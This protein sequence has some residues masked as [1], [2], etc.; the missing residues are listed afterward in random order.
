MRHYR[1][2]AHP[3]LQTDRVVSELIIGTHIDGAPY[4]AKVV[5]YFT[6]EGSFKYRMVEPQI[7][8]E[9]RNFYSG[10]CRDYVGTNDSAIHRLPSDPPDSYFQQELNLLGLWRRYEQTPDQWVPVME[11]YE[12]LFERIGNTKEQCWIGPP[13]DAATWPHGTGGWIVNFK[14]E[15]LGYGRQAS[16]HRLRNR[17]K[18]K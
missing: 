5:I 2:K 10:S 6:S 11:D 15:C 18:G 13:Y 14:K 1:I 7:T 9:P 17:N 8:S 16:T 3:V 12:R 4:L